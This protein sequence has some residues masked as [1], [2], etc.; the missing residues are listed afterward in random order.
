MTFITVLAVLAFLYLFI[1]FPEYIGRREFQLSQSREVKVTIPEGFNV[2]QIGETLERSG[3]GKKEQFVEAAKNQEGFLFPDTYR[4]YKDAT[5][6]DIIEKMRENFNKK[7]DDDILQE[8]VH[9]KYT[10][11]N[12]VI[13]A[14]LL[15]EEVKSTEDRKLVA[16]ILWKR[17]SLNMGLNVDAALTYVL[18][19]TS[20]E[21]TQED[22]KYDSP[23]N[24]YRYRGLPP[25]PISN[26]GLDAILAALRPTSSQY[27]YY[28]TD[29]DGSVHYAK[30]LEEHKINKFR[31]LK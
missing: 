23:Y 27:L 7:I 28:L 26:S 1:K 5:P 24:T 3:L 6:K 15:E 8:I 30:N 14:S 17:L 9:E 29:K 11:T 22:L 31:Y 21:L 10:L 18:G 12:I 19:K 13:M 4:F 16:G 20:H 2:R 25:G